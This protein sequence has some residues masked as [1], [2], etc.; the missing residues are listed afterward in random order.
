MFNPITFKSK[1]LLLLAHEFS[2]KNNDYLIGWNIKLVGADKLLT[3][4][5]LNIN[6]DITA[7]QQEKD[8]KYEKGQSNIA[9]LEEDSYDFTAAGTGAT[10]KYG[11]KTKWVGVKQQFFNTTVIA[12]TAFSYAEATLII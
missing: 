9:H 12:G 4:G 6:W 11:D 1:H 5:V 10:K 2:I 8:L 3:Q 7:H